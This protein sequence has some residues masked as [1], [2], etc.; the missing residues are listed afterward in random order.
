MNNSLINMIKRWQKPSHLFYVIMAREFA[1]K[2]YKSKE[3]KSV[4]AVAMA[5]AGG[6]C[7]SIG[8]YNPAEE[9]HHMIYLTPQNISDPSV[10][11]NV[12][13]L[14]CLCRDCHQAKH[15][16]DRHNGRKK[17]VYTNNWEKQ[18]LFNENGEPIEAPLSKRSGGI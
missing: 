4:R 8:C 3:W 14:E 16:V 18:I 2:F 9:V 11:L 6:M 13:K 15:R 10:A 5:R 17:S 1:Q 7:E 12:D